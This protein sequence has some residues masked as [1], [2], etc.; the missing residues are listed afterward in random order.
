[1]DRLETLLAY[2]AEDPGDSFVRFALASE[3]SKLG[4]AAEALIT[5][6]E[7]R[8][9]EPSYI[10]TYYHLGKLYEALDRPED[11]QLTYRDGIAEATRQKDT[12]S[13]S[14]LQAALLEAEAW[15]D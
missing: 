11:A 3:Y 14:E 12:H 13:R 6:E 5:F 4:R 9:H 7:S 10:G 2:H 15:G 8:R 1:M